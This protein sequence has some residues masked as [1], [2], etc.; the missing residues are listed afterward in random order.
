MQMLSVELWLR[1]A[2]LRNGL[3]GSACSTNFQIPL[4]PL[5]SSGMYFMPVCMYVCTHVPPSSVLLHR[6]SA[7]TYFIAA[8]W[9]GRENEC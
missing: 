3:K 5:G 7:G 1:L 6:H 8:L 4:H 2:R 9:V